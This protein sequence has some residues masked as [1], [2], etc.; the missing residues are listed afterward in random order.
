MI[1]N[2]FK[3]RQQYGGQWSIKDSRPLNESE[4]KMFTKAHVQDFT[5]EDGNI[6]LS[7]CFTMVNGRKTYVPTHDSHCKYGI[8][9]EVP[10]DEIKVVTLQK[11]GEADITRLN[12]E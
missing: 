4:R 11:D 1:E 7:I 10:M 5:H 3:G 6:S 12:V 2:I 8:G 9:E